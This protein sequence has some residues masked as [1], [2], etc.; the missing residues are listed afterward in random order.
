[1]DRFFASP[2]DRFLLE[3]S[4][5]HARSAISAQVHPF[6]LTTLAKVLFQAM[7]KSA[8]NRDTYFSEAW[9]HVVEANKREAQWSNRGATLFVIAFGG[10][11]S[12]LK[13]GGQLTGEQY[14]YLRDMIAE[15]RVLKISD[16]RLISRRAELEEEVA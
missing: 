12:F 3:E 13:M 15:T 11:L 6:S 14:E 5:Q 16:K 10:V 2:N 4:I 1:M 7:E 8:P 9:D